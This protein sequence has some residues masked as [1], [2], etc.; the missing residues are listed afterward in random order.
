M[1]I[2]EFNYDLPPELIAQTPAESRDGSRLLILDRRSGATRHGMFRD[3]LAEV[4][5]GDLWVFNDTRVIPARLYGKREGTGAKVEMLLLHPLGNDRWEVL[6]KPGKKAIPGDCIRFAPEFVAQVEERTDFGG[7]V[8]KFSYHDD[9]DLLLDK[10]G[11][12]PLPPYIH[13]KLRDKERY[14]TVYSRIQGSAAAPTAGLHFTPEL[15]VEMKERGAEIHYVTLHVGLGTFRPVS[16]EK[17]EDHVM[18]EEYYAVKEETA[19]AVNRA[20]DEGRRVVAVGTTSVRTLEAASGSGRLMAGSGKT[21]LFI[22]PGYEFRIVDAMLTNFHLP[23]S[24]L[25]MM[26]SAFAGRDNIMKAYHEAVEAKYRFFSFGD[27]MWIR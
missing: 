12:M 23:Q 10:H 21:E 5:A 24:T 11:E 6:V 22:Y 26:I 13:K 9:F 16:V 2:S 17:I 25:L 18:H 7:R 20:K 19:A 8:V 1:N 27:A 14:Q 15:M 4:R 3:I